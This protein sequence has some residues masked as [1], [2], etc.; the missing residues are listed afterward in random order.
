MAMIQTRNYGNWTRKAGVEAKRDSRFWVYIPKTDPDR[1]GFIYKLDVQCE[2][3]LHKRNWG[4]SKVFG[5]K[6]ETLTER[7]K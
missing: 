3:R 5:L 7:K 1:Q 6:S 4:G 2:K